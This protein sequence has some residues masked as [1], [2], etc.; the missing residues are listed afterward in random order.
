MRVTTNNAARDVVDASMLPADV[1]RQFDY[2]D[3]PAIDAGEASASF[4]RYR[5]DWYDLA[6]FMRVEPG[7]ELASCGWQ[8]Y[9]ADSAFSGVVV[10]LTDGGEGVVVGRCLS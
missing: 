9:A 2:L 4:F 10:R 5:G 1:R 3:W 7:D 8:G 6:E